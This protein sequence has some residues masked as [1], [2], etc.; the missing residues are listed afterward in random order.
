MTKSQL[1]LSAAFAGLVAAAATTAAADDGSKCY[2]IAKAG[3]NAC[4]S[5]TGAHACKGL[6][7]TDNDPGDWV[8]L[9]PADCTKTGGS[10]TA[11]SK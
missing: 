1:L 7:K 10:T 8:L 3:Q 2:G 5:A 4:A 6:A 9:A 11:P